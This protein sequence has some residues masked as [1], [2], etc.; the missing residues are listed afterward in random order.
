LKFQA[1]RCD[2]TQGHVRTPVTNIN[3]QGVLGVLGEQESMKIFET[4]RQINRNADVA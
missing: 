3:D 2:G 4:L 1:E